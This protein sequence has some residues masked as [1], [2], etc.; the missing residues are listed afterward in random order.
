VVTG[1]VHQHAA[2]VDAGAGPPTALAV[3]GTRAQDRDGDALLGTRRQQ[4]PGLT[5]V[6]PARLGVEVPPP[7]RR[8][9]SSGRSDALVRVEP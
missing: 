8:G 6:G 9:E 7:E 4:R 1:R 3:T 2:D 5:D